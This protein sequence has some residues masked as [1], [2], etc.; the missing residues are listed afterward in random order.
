MDLGV[1]TMIE[2]RLT[3][4]KKELERLEDWL[5]TLPHGEWDRVVI[6]QSASNGIGST[7]VAYATGP[8]HTQGW[9]KDI[10]DVTEW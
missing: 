2:S 5:S 1:V 9:F 8:G 4:T 10:T 3:I 6:E 7:I